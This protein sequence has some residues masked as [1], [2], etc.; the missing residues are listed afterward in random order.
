MGQ[1]SV[2]VSVFGGETVKP[3]LESLLVTCD[4]YNYYFRCELTHD[5]VCICG[6]YVWIMYLS[7]G[8]H[9]NENFICT[10]RTTSSGDRR[11]V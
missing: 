7:M 5:M 10:W 1:V 4:M 8:L 11:Q 3:E 6:I 2:L 9:Q